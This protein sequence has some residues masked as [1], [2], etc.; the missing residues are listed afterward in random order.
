MNSKK[1]FFPLV[2][3]IIVNYNGKTLLE[4]CLDSI[5][6]ITYSN[7]EI[8][9]VDNNS[10]DDSID[11]V[12]K[13]YP[14]STIVK[15]STNKGFAEPNN[16]GAKIAKGKYLLFL[17][18]D[19]KV[20]KNFLTEMVNTIEKNEKISICQSLLLKSDGSVDS[21]GDFVDKIGIVYNS[22][23]LIQKT[24]KIFSARAA[25]MLIR[26]SIFDKLGGF[27]EQF[28]FSFEDVDLCWRSWI[29]GYESII[30][31]TSVVYHLGST[32]V[33]KFRNESTFHGTKNQ[34]SMKITNFEFPLSIKNIFL[35]FG[36]Y[37]SREIKI[38]F[39]Y[40][41]KGK[42]NMTSTKFEDKIADKPNFIIIFKAIF[43]LIRNYR[44]LFKKYRTINSQRT[45]ST[46]QLKEMNL[47]SDNKQ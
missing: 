25:S 6:K 15:L 42:T 39:D 1:T 46:K 28:R 37:G 19:T 20:L 31:P 41:L 11:F 4:T 43:W 32:T 27:D 36:I 26:K 14:S 45:M 7:I 22:K 34:L 3:I 35:F 13:K 23:N 12:E 9:L 5:S 18:N 17:N 10:T 29:L 33:N 47:I 44:Y 24:R 8:I 38:W 30:I 2:S 21:S 40:N 16:V